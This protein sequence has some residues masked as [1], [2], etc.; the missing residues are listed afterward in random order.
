KEGR[1]IFDPVADAAFVARLKEKLAD[2]ERVKEVDLHLYTP[3][4]ARFAVDEFMRLY[5]G[6]HA[7][8]T[9]PSVS[10]EAAH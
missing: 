3:E 8:L 9:T 7:P 1:P 10:V 5:A 2:P 6:A 4:F